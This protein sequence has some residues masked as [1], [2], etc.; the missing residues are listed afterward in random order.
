MLLKYGVVGSGAV[1]KVVVVVCRYWVVATHDMLREL[2]VER[3]R[4][5]RKRAKGE[6]KQNDKTEVRVK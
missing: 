5:E 3:V 1:R 2:V 6:Q 4:G